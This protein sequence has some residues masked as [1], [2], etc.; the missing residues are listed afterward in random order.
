MK[1]QS[2]D[3]LCFLFP[4][5]H[6]PH[7]QGCDLIEPHLVAPG[8]IPSFLYE[9][10]KAP[11]PHFLGY[12]LIKS[13]SECTNQIIFSFA[14]LWKTY[15]VRVG[16]L[17]ASLCTH[18]AK[19]NTQFDPNTLKYFITLWTN[20]TPL[21]PP[22][23]G[24]CQQLFGASPQEEPSVADFNFRHTQGVECLKIFN[25]DGLGHPINPNTL[26][27]PLC[28]WSLSYGELSQI[29]KSPQK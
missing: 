27:C 7:L 13:R 20:V 22:T 4:T 3:N 28:S 29:F 14:S 21:P 10:S 5:S 9:R 12:K 23:V 11:F 15:R 8:D 17:L 25:W 24:I 2:S 16:S 19:A 6:Q 18:G 1:H 26:G